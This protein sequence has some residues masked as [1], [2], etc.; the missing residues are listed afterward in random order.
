MN[1][2]PAAEFPEVILPFNTLSVKTQAL[3]Q[4]QDS[5]FSVITVDFKA[6]TEKLTLIQELFSGECISRICKQCLEE[7]PMCL[8]GIHYP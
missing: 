8:Q 2:F 6:R 3:P 5:G 7:I 4:V 1:R